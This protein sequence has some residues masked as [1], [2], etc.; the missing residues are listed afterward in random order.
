MFDLFKNTSDK[1]R[2]NLETF[3]AQTPLTDA[4]KYKFY[5][6]G[7][8]KKEHWLDFPEQEHG[9]N[10]RKNAADD[11]IKVDLMSFR[12]WNESFQN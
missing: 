11:H 8:L 9:W 1:F 4:I 7:R 2:Q 5:S 10:Q 3:L 12:D 6:I